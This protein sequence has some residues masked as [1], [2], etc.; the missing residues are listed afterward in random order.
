M[1]EAKT[2]Q[3]H[4]RL[5]E[6]QM[7]KIRANARACGKTVSAYVTEV[8]LY[9]CVLNYEYEDVIA[10]NNEI[11]SLRNTINQLVYT[12]RK[13]GEYVPADLEYILNKMNEISRSECEFSELMLYEKEQKARVVA[14]TAREIVRKRLASMK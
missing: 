12:I 10:H 13:T 3:L 8:S 4:I 7:E 2:E 11:T 6:T 1:R 14:R 9:F 5:T